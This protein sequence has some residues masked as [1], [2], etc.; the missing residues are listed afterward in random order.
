MSYDILCFSHLRWHFVFQR[1]QHLL[2]RFALEGHRVFYI[3]EP[4]YDAS[5]SSYYAINTDAKTGVHIVVMH[6]PPNANG[7]SAYH[8]E[9]LTSA[10]IREN[11][12]VEFVSWYYAPMAI[13][14]TRHL[15][16]V[17]LVYDCMDEL[18]A[19]KFAPP[20][21]KENEKMLMEKADVVF[22]GGYSLFEA[23][24]EMHGNIHAFPSSIDKLHFGQARS[25]LKDPPDQQ[26]IPHPRL[27]F[28]G[29]IDERLDVELL[30][31]LADERPAYHL[32]I[33]GP[34]VKIDPGILP[35]RNNIH[36]LGGKTYDEL[37]VYLSGWDIAIMPFALNES[38]AFI[39]PTKTPEFL[40]GGK[41]VISTPIRDV[42]NPYGVKKL[43]RI[44]NSAGD[45][46]SNADDLLS[47]GMNKEWRDAVDTFLE[48]LSWDNTWSKMAEQ[49]AQ[50]IKGS[51][52]TSTSKKSQH[53]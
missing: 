8:L 39:S 46:A 11:N 1:P 49:I 52:I 3:E 32:V 36:Y 40:A 37:P 25:A 24:K 23:K 34:V 27:G 18:S 26:S 47:M 4:L 45:F 38:T 35:V 43:V 48:D 6:L 20:L 30:G 19:F 5:E 22:T 50:I 42:V 2:R 33:I 14:F 13:E 29:V 21:L 12:I 51:N 15:Q 53:V 7:Q 9:L 17:A 16:P 41:P 10:L 28:F 31:N 44:A